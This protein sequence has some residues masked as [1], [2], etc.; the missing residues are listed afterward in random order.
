[1]DF[2]STLDEADRPPKTSAVIERLR[3]DAQLREEREAQTVVEDDE[4]VG[5][6]RSDADRPVSE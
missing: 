6:R 4:A 5:R 1:M 2:A 3:Q